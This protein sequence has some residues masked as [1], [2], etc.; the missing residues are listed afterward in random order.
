MNITDF[1]EKLSSPAPTPGGGG[2]AALVGAIGMA[3]GHMTASLTLGKKRYASVQSQ[4][5]AFCKEASELESELLGQIE[6]DAAC[7]A[8]LAEAYRI[9]KGSPGREETLEAAT[10]LACSAPEKV[11]ELCCRGIALTEE[12]SAV[13]SR[14]ALSDAACSAAILRAALESAAVNLFI[15]T[16]SLQDR[17]LAE[18]KNQIAKARLSGYLPRAERIYRD[19]CGNYGMG[20]F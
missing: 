10:V 11:M 9:P 4:V 6:A 15:N 1:I 8:P 12:I 17:T 2:A 5:E 18:E 14:Q 20:E 3:A 13:G 7:F 16:S 19:I